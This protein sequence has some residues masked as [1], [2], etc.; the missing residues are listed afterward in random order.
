MNLREIDA[1]KIN[2]R[3]DPVRLSRRER[4]NCCR[5]DCDMHELEGRMNIK[6]LGLEDASLVLAGGSKNLL[7]LL[8]LGH[9]LEELG[10]EFHYYS[11]SQNP[12]AFVCEPL[13]LSLVDEMDDSVFP[14]TI[15]DNKILLQGRYP[16]E[17]DF[18][19][20]TGLDFSD[21]DLEA[22]AE[23]QAVLAC[24][25][26]KVILCDC[27]VSCVDCHSSSVLIDDETAR[28]MNDPSR[29]DLSENLTNID[30]QL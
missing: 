16:D 13:V 3:P 11:I 9:R 27:G 18:C 28:K 8:A 23:L 29:D 26:Y 10:H 7:L 2:D 25:S 24:N 22:E 30:D 5:G 19:C 20:W 12:E 21:L 6:V 1:I 4:K 15:A 17:E 14:V